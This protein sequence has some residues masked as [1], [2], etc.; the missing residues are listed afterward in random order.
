MAEAVVAKTDEAK[1]LEEFKA[2][3]AEAAK[4]FKERRAAEKAERIEKAKKLMAELQKAGLFDK[5]SV[6][7][8]SFIEGLAVPATTGASSSS[9]F[10][11]IYGAT[12]KVG[13]KKTLM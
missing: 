2:R 11:V 7:S 12:P 6:E 9:L 3:K 5:L 10:N 13:D 8:K 1:K 4:K